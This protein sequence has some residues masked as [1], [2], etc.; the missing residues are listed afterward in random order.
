MS[1]SDIVS[2]IKN[3]IAEQVGSR[4]AVQQLD[5]ISDTESVAETLYGLL[6][7][8]VNN[9]V[10]DSPN[11]ITQEP[12]EWTPPELPNIQIQPFTPK[13]IATPD[14]LALVS[15]NIELSADGGTTVTATISCN[16]VLGAAEYE[17]RLSGG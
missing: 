12:Y 11:L 4:Q 5:Q 1:D 3:L 17:F 16:D 13:D 6:S 10:Q 14:N 7:A 15:Q 9:D 8:E 2:I